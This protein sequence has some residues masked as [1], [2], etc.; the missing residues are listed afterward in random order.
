MKKIINFEY[1]NGIDASIEING[2]NLYDLILNSPKY[3]SEQFVLITSEIKRVR[4]K[5]MNDKRS[6]KIVEI[7]T[8][9]LEL[10]NELFELS[11]LIKQGLSNKIVDTTDDQPRYVKMWLDEV[12]DNG[13]KV[14]KF[15]CD[16]RN[17]KCNKIVKEHRNSL[18][19]SIKISNKIC[20]TQE[21]LQN[22]LS[23]Q[24]QMKI[25]KST[26]SISPNCYTS[27]VNNIIDLLNLLKT[28]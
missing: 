14:I 15:N 10:L 27:V 9:R 17:E 18:I 23:Q 26:L 25:N 3:Y 1:K 12:K 8:N 13:N 28:N 22:L 7:D 6:R 19:C 2:Q 16:Q 24:L 5:M 20:D 21:D 4:D 11:T